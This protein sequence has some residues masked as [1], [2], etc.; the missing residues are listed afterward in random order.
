MNYM[1]TAHLVEKKYTCNFGANNSRQVIE[2][3][4]HASHIIQEHLQ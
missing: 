2:T 4:D 1:S 3:L